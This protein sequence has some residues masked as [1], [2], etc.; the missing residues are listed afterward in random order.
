MPTET[1]HESDNTSSDPLK[2]ISDTAKLLE[3]IGTLMVKLYTGGAKF[4][5]PQYKQAATDFLSIC[6]DLRGYAGNVL[7]FIAPYRYFSFYKP[8]DVIRDE[9]KQL[10]VKYHS[11][12][13][14]DW[15]SR[16]KFRCSDIDTAYNRHCRSWIKN[17]YGEHVTKQK[18]DR[19]DNLLRELT[20]IDAELV[21][22]ISKQIM[23]P[24]SEFIAAADDAHTKNDVASLKAAYFVFRDRTKARFAEVESTLQELEAAAGSFQQLAQEKQSKRKR[25]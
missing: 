10:A 8:D 12:K 25:A 17:K 21:D 22:A 18:Q 7:E 16:L 19:A 4:V 9:F 15:I 6:A 5:T 13:P 23:Q 3:Q 14:G 20:R 24:L 11:K 1:E 2:K